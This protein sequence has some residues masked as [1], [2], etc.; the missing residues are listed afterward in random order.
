MRR[1][2]E[3]A[4]RLPNEIVELLNTK[5]IPK[6]AVAIRKAE[7]ADM[8]LTTRGCLE[9]AARMRAE[10]EVFEEAHKLD[11]ARGEA[12]EIDELRTAK[13]SLEDQVRTLRHENEQK[14]RQIE[15]FTAQSAL[16]VSS[17][18]SQR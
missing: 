16:A 18:G 3:P 1:R 5:G 6:T 9:L 7:G 15:R 13:A 2:D 14:D 17:G 12:V 4:V 11:Q 10:R 8:P